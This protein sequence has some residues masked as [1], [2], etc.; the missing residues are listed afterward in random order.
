M[1][2]LLQFDARGRIT[3]PHGFR[4]ALGPR[5]VAILT[6]HGVVLHPVPEHVDTDAVPDGEQAALEEA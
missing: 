4:D 2:H 3:I 6:P 5:V 1:T